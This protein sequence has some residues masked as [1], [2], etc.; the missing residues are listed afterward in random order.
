MNIRNFLQFTVALLFLVTL[1]I[2]IHEFIH[3]LQLHYIYNIPL[4]NIELHFFW[5]FNTPNLA[6]HQQPIAYVSW[7]NYSMTTPINLLHMEIQAY[8][9]QYVFLTITYIKYIDKNDNFIWRQQ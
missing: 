7:S 1:S 4:N 9:I 5:E 2:F 6:L 8:F 3:I